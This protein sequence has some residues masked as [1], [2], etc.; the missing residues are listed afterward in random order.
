VTAHVTIALM[1][2]NTVPDAIQRAPCWT[3][4]SK[5]K[6]QGVLVR[7]QSYLTHATRRFLEGTRHNSP[8]DAVLAGVRTLDVWASILDEEREL[9]QI[10]NQAL[11]RS[12]RRRTSR[13]RRQL[14]KAREEQ[15]ATPRTQHDRPAG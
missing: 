2:E 7:K 5:F 13:N 8:I 11:S 3:V 1:L 10:R 6:T 14:A 9:E 15:D 12:G 4:F